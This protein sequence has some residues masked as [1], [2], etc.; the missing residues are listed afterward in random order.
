MLGTS[1]AVTC[2]T[3]CEI[4]AV[5]FHRRPLATLGKKVSFSCPQSGQFL[6]LPQ[7]STKPGCPRL[8]PSVCSLKSLLRKTWVW[9]ERAS[10]NGFNL[11]L[12]LS[13][14]FFRTFHYLQLVTW[15]LVRWEQRIRWRDLNLLLLLWTD[16]DSRKLQKWNIRDG[17]ILY[18]TRLPV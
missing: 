3:I 18:K 5:R 16:S 14:G 10:K 1:V 6:L 13:T 15:T 7:Y 9:K 4:T 11:C 17:N 2:H 8:F 12:I